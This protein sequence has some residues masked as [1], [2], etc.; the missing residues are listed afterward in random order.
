MFTFAIREICTGLIVTRFN[1]ICYKFNNLLK[2]KK[3]TDGAYGLRG[4]ID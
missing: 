2:N 4:R 1:R 3:N